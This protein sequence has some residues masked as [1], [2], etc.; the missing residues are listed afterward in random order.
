MAV[1]REG[2]KEGG[3]GR[4]GRKSRERMKKRNERSR[5]RRGKN[6]GGDR[7][8]ERRKHIP[9]HTGFFFFQSHGVSVIS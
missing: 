1:R 8:E 2:G 6:T 9:G 5:G 7:V 3:T 4:G